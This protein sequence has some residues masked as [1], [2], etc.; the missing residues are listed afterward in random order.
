[1][2]FKKKKVE[3]RD[4]IISYKKVFGSAE[5]KEVLFDLL[6]KYHVLNHHK[7]DDAFAEG[8]RSVALDILHQCN[9]NLEAFDQLLKG[10][11]E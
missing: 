6:N 3:H 2:F 4:R 9:I 8:Q 1:M 7:G 11:L 10:E 5:G